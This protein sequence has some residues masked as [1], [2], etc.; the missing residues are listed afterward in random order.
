M[1]LYH[2]PCQKSLS[3]AIFAVVDKI[4]FHFAALAKDPEAQKVKD[5][6]HKLQKAFLGK[7]IPKDEVCI[8]FSIILSTDPLNSRL[9]STKFSDFR[10][11]YG[12]RTCQASQNSSQQSRNTK[13]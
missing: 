1:F 10:Y 6:R 9:F 7:V 12:N 8:P 13:V 5:W 2:G 4:F 11:F 3:S